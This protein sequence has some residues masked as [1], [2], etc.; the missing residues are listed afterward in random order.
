MV[1]ESKINLINKAIAAYFTVNKD[2]SVV[3]AKDLMP[4]FVKA[5]I[6]PA[7]HKKGLPIRNILRKLDAD[8]SLHLIPYALPEHKQKNTSWFFA[9][10]PKAKLQRTL[11]SI[12]VEKQQ[13]AI[14]KRERDEK[15]VID[16]CDEVLNIKAQRQHLFDFLLG[17]EGKDGRRRKLPVDAY[18]PDLKLVVEY[19]EEQHTQEVKH[20]DKPEVMTVS[21]VHRGLQRKLYDERRR[22]ELPKHGIELVE[23]PFTTFACD[24][25]N[26]IIRNKEN[27]LKTIK[28]LLK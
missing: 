2:I 15:Y 16:L 8:N 5:G 25:R 23:I 7:D 24:R 4:Q 9:R 20:F 18:Y 3:M 28:S 10:S 6:F 19:R 21:G 13:K 11:S 1:A 22:K 27:D 12:T 26:R 17:D 14:S